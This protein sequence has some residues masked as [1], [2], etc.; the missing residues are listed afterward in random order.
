MVGAAWCT[1]Y[2]ATRSSVPTARSLEASLGTVGVTEAVETPFE[3]GAPGSGYAPGMLLLPLCI[4]RVL[5]VLLVSPF[6]PS[7]PTPT[8]CTTRATSTIAAHVPAP[9]SS[10]ARSDRG[11]ISGWSV[12]GWGGVSGG[13]GGVSQ[14]VGEGGGRRGD[15]KGREGKAGR[16]WQE[17]Q[18][19]KAWR[20]QRR[21]ETRAL[22]PGKGQTPSALQCG[23]L[24]SIF[25]EGG[26]ASHLVS[27]LPA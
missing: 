6:P 20:R 21:D 15:G 13:G 27:S 12:S 7:L 16:A 17:G 1:S 11:S 9:T 8:P 10:T 26:S 2:G 23:Q 3:L 18:R 22:S 24:T 14:G 19:G 25:A 5:P 4:S